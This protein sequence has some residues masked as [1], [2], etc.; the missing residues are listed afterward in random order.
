MSERTS[1]RSTRSEQETTQAIKREIK[2]LIGLTATAARNGVR[3]V[4]PFMSADELRQVADDQR[5]RVFAMID[6]LSAPPP[7]TPDDPEAV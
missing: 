5:D 2:T 3:G 7:A 6:V 4:P 1:E